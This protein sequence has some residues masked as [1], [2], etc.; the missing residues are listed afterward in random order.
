MNES[1][2][3]KKIVLGDGLEV[4]HEIITEEDG[5]GFGLAVADIVRSEAHHHE[6]GMV[7]TY[8][9]ISGSLVVMVDGQD[10]ILKKPGNTLTIL[11]GQRHYARSENGKTPARI[12]VLSTPAWRPENHHLV[13]G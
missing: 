9:L 13:N 4:V 10:F 6:E 2:Y 12:T 1:W 3:K 5:L 7:E 8:T 11:P